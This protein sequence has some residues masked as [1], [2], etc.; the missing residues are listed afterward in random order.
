M[1]LPIWLQNSSFCKLFLLEIF[2]PKDHEI[3][4]MPFRSLQG[5]VKIFKA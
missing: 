1:R 2:A 3:G 4:I 5:L